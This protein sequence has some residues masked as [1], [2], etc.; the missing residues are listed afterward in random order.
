MQRL[1]I[2]HSRISFYLL[3]IK[4]ADPIH[5]LE[6]WKTIRRRRLHIYVVIIHI[7][8]SFLEFTIKI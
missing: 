2:K 1:L 8:Y 5:E 4:L 7:M 6:L 3:D